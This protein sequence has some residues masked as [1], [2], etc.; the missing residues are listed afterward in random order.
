M[1]SASI[2]DCALILIELMSSCEMPELGSKV[3]IVYFEPSDIPHPN[4]SAALADISRVA[5]SRMESAPASCKRS[6][7]FSEKSTT[8]A[9]APQT[10]E[11][12]ASV[13]TSESRPIALSFPPFRDMSPALLPLNIPMSILPESTV[14][15]PM[16]SFETFFVEYDWAS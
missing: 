13:P 4:K 10:S 14:T 7:P 1:S 8:K 16:P 2:P 5:D 6:A 12:A 9:P 11:F 15:L 3:K